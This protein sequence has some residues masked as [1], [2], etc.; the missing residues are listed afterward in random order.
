MFRA[1]ARHVP[2]AV[3]RLQRVLDVI[4]MVGLEPRIRIHAQAVQ[5]VTVRSLGAIH[6]GTALHVRPRL[7]SFV[8]YD[9]RL[10]EAAA[11]AGLPVEMPGG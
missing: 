8:T 9:V 3:R 10:S 2:G 4:D 1:L 11:A 5:P 7:T 6:V